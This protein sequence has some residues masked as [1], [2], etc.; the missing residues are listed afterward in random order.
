[1]FRDLQLAPI[2]MLHRIIKSWLFRMWDLDFIGQIHPASCKGHRFV[3][4]AT[5]YFTKWMEVV[6]LKNMTYK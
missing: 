6:L 5:D 1:M 3:L 4:V 2:T